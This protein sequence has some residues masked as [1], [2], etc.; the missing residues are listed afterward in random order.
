MSIALEP[1]DI[2]RFRSIVG[3]RLGLLF[4]DDKLDYLADVLR[5]RLEACCNPRPDAYLRRLAGVAPDEV[6]ALAERLTVA[7]TYFFRYLDHFRAFAEVVLPERARAQAGRRELRILSAGCASGEEAYSLAV[8]VREHLADARSWNVKIRGI[9][10]NRAV[11]ER[12]ARG[13]YSAWSLRETPAAMRERYFRAEGRDF[14]L[15]DAVRPLVTFEERNLVEDDAA[16]W[17]PG[18]FDVVFC[19][20]VTMYFTPDVMRAVVARIAHALSPGGFLFLGHAE[21]LRGIS[22]DF[23]LCHTHDT[24][25]YQRRSDHEPIASA[26]FTPP[27]PRAA[28]EAVPLAL[29]LGLN[30]SSWVDVIQGASDRIAKLSTEPRPPL[31]S[32]VASGSA[33]RPAWDLR[34]AVEMLR[35]ERFADAIDLLQALPAGSRA[36]PDAELLR[37]VLLTNS[38]KL[39]EA[40]RVCEQILAMDELNAGAHYV[41]AL[42]REHAGDLRGARERDQVATYLD[43]VFAMPHLHL[44]LL[45]RRAGDSEQ[46]QS[47][48]RLALSLLAR[49]DASRILLFGGGFTREALVELCHAELRRSGGAS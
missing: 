34:P 5:E 1:A 15:D 8:L 29:A 26:P 36:D 7:E 22:K 25:Y 44:G 45:A 43:P 14:Q 16:F 31:A 48:L 24:F 42:C 11:L 20:N 9:D 38:G 35:Q 30:D 46:A 19:R 33:P 6:R 47:E 23:H 39:P 12:A 3:T 32:S 17:Q 28:G 10:V 49:E 37:A 41:A 40:E 4:E 18:A 2:A 21:T 13:R 27:A